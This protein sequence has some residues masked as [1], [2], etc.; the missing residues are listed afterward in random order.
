MNKTAD[1]RTQGK[2]RNYNE[3]LPIKHARPAL[4]E[5]QRSF[6]SMYQLQGSQARGGSYKNKSYVGSLDAIIH[7]HVLYTV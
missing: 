2:L 4:K 5:L 7:Q 6:S 1:A 3:K